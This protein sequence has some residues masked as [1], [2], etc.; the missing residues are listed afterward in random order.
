MSLTHTN[1]ESH[2]AEYKAEDKKEHKKE[3][4]ELLL[5]FKNNVLASQWVYRQLL[6]VMSEPATILPLSAS[7]KT[8][9]LLSS[10]P[11]LYEDDWENDQLYSTTW[12]IAQALLDS[13]CQVHISDTLSKKEILQ[14]LRFYTDAK[15][16]KNTQQAQFA[17]MNLDEWISNN[18][19]STGSL[20]APHE[21]C[22]LVV[23]VKDMS[24]DLD[25]DSRDTQLVL[26]GPGIKTQKNLSI[27][28][29]TQLQ[30]EFLTI[31]NQLYP[32]G[33]DIIFCSPTHITALPRSTIISAS[34]TKNSSTSN[35]S[36]NSEV[37]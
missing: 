8:T 22:T 28:G 13:D 9:S 27:F 25:G 17:F 14:S 31:N 11:K 24:N 7:A 12:S 2:S 6:K 29:L 16:N 21:S 19:Y 15:I 37:A 36:T 1:N 5:A 30:I 20:I 32:C 4:L 33:L 3:S 35:F 18:E 23:Q 10:M 26:S 34:V